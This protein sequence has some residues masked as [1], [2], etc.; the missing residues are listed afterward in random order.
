MCAE[1]RRKNADFF[2]GWQGG[3]PLANPAFTEIWRGYDKG[4]AAIRSE[5]SAAVGEDLLPASALTAYD[6]LARNLDTLA[7]KRGGDFVDTPCAFMLTGAESLIAASPA[8]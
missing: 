8:L 4:A 1:T 7:G 2:A 3:N 6:E 5:I